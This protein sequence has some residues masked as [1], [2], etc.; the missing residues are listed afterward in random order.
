MAPKLEDHAIEFGTGGSKLG[1]MALRL[2][3]V[4]NARFQTRGPGIEIG[5]GG[6]KLD[7]LGIEI[8]TGGSK[9]EDLPSKRPFQTRSHGIEFGTARSKLK[10]RGSSLEPLVPNSMSWP[11][12][13]EPLAPTSRGAHFI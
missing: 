2:E 6:S 3:R 9:L 5:T 1:A 10:M 7:V 11:S 8:G 13:V 4:W 12:S